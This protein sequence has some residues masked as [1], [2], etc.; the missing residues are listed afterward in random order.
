MTIPA[1]NIIRSTVPRPILGRT[2]LGMSVAPSSIRV[3][4]S[5]DL[6]MSSIPA[7]G[8]SATSLGICYDAYHGT[9]IIANDASTDLA[10]TPDDGFSWSTTPVS[11][12]LKDVMHIPGTNR[13]IAVGIG[14]C[15]ITENGGASFSF[16][17]MPANVQYF[18]LDRNPTTGRIVAS[19]FG[20]AAYSDTNGDT[21]TTSGGVNSQ[22]KGV[23][24]APSLNKW[25]ISGDLGDG[26][27]WESTNDAVSFSVISTTQNCNRCFWDAGAERVIC[28]PWGSTGK[29]VDASGVHN[30][31]FSAGQCWDGRYIPEIGKSVMM[32][33]LPGN[34]FVSDDGF[35]TW[36]D[37]FAG[38]WADFAYRAA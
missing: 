5:T 28:C 14:R 19:G 27:V 1:I 24:W 11:G 12:T 8:L 18:A 38:P 21:W 29:Y 20:T 17:P 33:L 22:A 25:I 31:T 35:D 26:T 4:I 2:I 15:G 30:L 16:V 13:T 7:I 37:I 6:V 23:A 9:F 34:A 3:G 36:T 10:W 32:N